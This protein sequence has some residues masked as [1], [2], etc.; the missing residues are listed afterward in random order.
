MFKLLTIQTGTLIV[1]KKSRIDVP[2]FLKVF[3]IDVV[4]VIKRSSIVLKR[5]SHNVLIVFKD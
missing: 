4:T 5:S 2:I 3:R 1:L